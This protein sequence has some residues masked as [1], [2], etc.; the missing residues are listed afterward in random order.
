MDDRAVKGAT[1]NDPWTLLT[2]IYATTSNQNSEDSPS[3]SLL[4]MGNFTTASLA[5][6]KESLSIHPF[7]LLPDP[8]MGQKSHIRLLYEKGPGTPG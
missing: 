1:V 5:L 2:T 8:L 6:R 3:Q 7:P 4:T